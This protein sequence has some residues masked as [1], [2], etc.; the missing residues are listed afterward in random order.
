M[1][2]QRRADVRIAPPPLAVRLRRLRPGGPPGSPVD[3]EVLD[4]SG[5]GLRV[6][7]PEWLAD[8]DAVEL[9]LRLPGRCAPLHGRARVVHVDREG[10]HGL[11]IEHFEHGD[12][13][14]LVRFVFERQ[15]ELL[16]TRRGRRDPGAQT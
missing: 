9:E 5:G 14:V 13:E 3:A 8:G 2:A 4:L 7:G 12:R 6:A 11:D 16:A 1:S 10:N 15:R